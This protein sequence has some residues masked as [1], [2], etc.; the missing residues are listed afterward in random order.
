MA[1]RKRTFTKKCKLLQHFPV[2]LKYTEP[3]QNIPSDVSIALIKT[4]GFTVQYKQV[5]ESDLPTGYDIYIYDVS[6]KKGFTKKT[7]HVRLEG[8]PQNVKIEGL[9]ADTDYKVRMRARNKVGEGKWTEEFKVKTG[10]SSFHR[11]R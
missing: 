1:F 3:P 11:K 4:T 2:L 6:T 5:P 9:V 8:R 10:R 7:N